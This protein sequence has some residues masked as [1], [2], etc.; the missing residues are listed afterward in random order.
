MDRHVLQSQANYC[1]PA[2]V[3]MVEA[4]RG[5]LDVAPNERQ[6]QLFAQLSHGGLCSLAA[7]K[8]IVPN[9][10][11][12][13]P[14]IADADLIPMLAELVQQGRRVIVTC[15]PGVLA[16]ILAPKGLSSPYGP[17]PMH[18]A[19]HHAIFVCGAS[20][21][22]FDV[23]D[24]WHHAERQPIRLL[25]DELAEAWTGMMLIATK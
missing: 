20:E 17:L 12:G 18:N 7:A 15:W 1:V 22:A 10:G 11:C 4:W 8:E 21:E 19:P 13:H 25:H 14:D 9:Q 6:E 24:P 2:C 5:T 16:Q 23:Y 3:V